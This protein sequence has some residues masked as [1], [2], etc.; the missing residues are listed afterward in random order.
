MGFSRGF[1]PPKEMVDEYIDK[2]K[3]TSKDYIDLNINNII[4][5]ILVESFNYPDNSLA[6]NLNLETFIM[7]L[8]WD[9]KKL[10]EMI[11]ADTFLIHKE[12]YDSEGYFHVAGWNYRDNE[13]RLLK[14]DVYNITIK[15]I[16]LWAATLKTDFFKD[17][18]G[19]YKK[20]EKIEETLSYF[21]DSMIEFTI[22]DFMNFFKDYENKSHDE[23][24]D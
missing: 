15:E 10:E 9:L 3:S 22:F 20:Q 16:T 12:I 1:T 4:T 18:N 23:D 11:K 13:P 19:Y 17:E 24:E 8:T 5:N 14:N 7:R 2:L 21:Q 6:N